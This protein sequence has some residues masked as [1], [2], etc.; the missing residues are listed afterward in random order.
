M[1]YLAR[2]WLLYGARDDRPL[3]GHTVFIGSVD[4]GGMVIESRFIGDLSALTIAQSAVSF[5]H[6]C[7]MADCRMLFQRGIN[8]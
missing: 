5:E 8:G 4:A 3:N 7:C 6:R 2:Q 1:A